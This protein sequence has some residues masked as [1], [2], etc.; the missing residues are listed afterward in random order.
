MTALCAMPD[1]RLRNR[2]L[3]ACPGGCDGCLPRIA[4]DGHTCERC[5][6]RAR[7]G[8]DAITLLAP[9]A[10]LVAA[11]LARIGAGHGTGK[12][13][14]RPPLNP[15]A[16]DTVHHV[17]TL[18]TTLA[19]DI[20]DTRGLTVPDAGARDP[21][22]VAARWLLAQVDWMRHAADEQGTP[23]AVAAFAEIGD[24]A[25]RL[26]SVVNG[27]GEQRYLGPCAAQIM[28]PCPTPTDPN[29]TIG[30]AECDGDVYGYPGADKG[31]CRTCGATV[32][33]EQRRIWLDDQVHASDL[34]WTARGIADAL[35]ISPK[36]VRGWAT[37]R[38]APNGVILR[39]AKLGTFWRD[40]D[41]LVP[42]TDPRPG[43]DVKARGERLHY[44]ADVIELARQAAAD[45]ERRK[46][47]RDEG[48]AA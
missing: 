22:V 37:A 30:P 42:W 47:N 11:G 29:A 9:D 24:C 18:L 27:P 21:I 7:G 31:A 36:T 45:R 33:Q 26:R 4:E 46:A 44:V 6:G 8:L 17:Q 28:L 19:R 39:R 15:D 38:V 5:D 3:P 35:D 32:D 43:E 23:Y 1:C 20:A 10:R 34:V 12:P 14:S 41:R 25:R 40:G 48:A 13:A 16:T 2:H